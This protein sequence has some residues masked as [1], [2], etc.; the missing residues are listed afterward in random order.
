MDSQPRREHFKLRG[1]HCAACATTIERAVASVPGVIEARV[2]F[3][4]E[5]LTVSLKNGA[6]PEAITGAVEAAGYTAIEAETAAATSELDRVEARRNLGWVIF[7]AIA[8]AAVMYLQDLSGGAAGLASLGLSSLVMFS[9]GLVFYR[10][11][12]IAAR[13]RTAGMDTL[14]ALGISAA[15]LYSVFTTFPS[16]FFE[17][18]RFFDTAV[19]LI[20]FVRLGKYLEARARGRATAALRALLQLTPERATVIRDGQETTIAASAVRVGDM[21]RV[22]PGEGVPVDGVIVEGSSAVDESMLTGE[23]MPVE[24]S[25]GREVSGGTLNTA[26]PLIIRA[27]R[28]GAETTVAQIVRMVEEAQADKAPIQRLADYVAARFVPAV[29]AI[30]AVTMAVWLWLGPSGV[31]ALTAAVAVLV[32]ACPCALGLATPTAIMVGSAIG[33]RSGILFKRASA[34]ELITRVQVILF[35]KTGTLTRGK[36]ELGRLIP[37][38]CDSRR[39]LELAAAAAFGSIHPLSRAVVAYAHRDGVEPAGGEHH[40]EFPGQGVT[41][42]SDGVAIA[43]GNERLL[44]RRQIAIPDEAGS[45]AAAMGAEGV[46]PLYLAA[47]AGVIAVLGFVDPLKP[48]A[49]DTLAALRARGIRTVMLSGDNRAVVKAVA[50]RLPLDEFHAEM[51]PEDKIALVR[52][53]QES[54]A[55]VG[56]VGDGINDAPALA[57]A[58]IGIAIGSGTDVAKETGEVV[59]TRDDLYDVVQAF[60]LGRMTLRKVKQNLFWAFFY[61]V[62][63]IPIAAGVLYPSFGILLNPALAGLAMALSSVSVVGNALTL[64]FYR[65]RLLAERQLHSTAINAVAAFHA[66]GPIARVARDTGK[67]RNANM[68]PA[69][70]AFKSEA[71]LIPTIVRSKPERSQEKSAMADTL[72]CAKCGYETAM[73]PHCNRPMHVEQVNDRPK[74]VC[75]MGPGCGVDEI[76]L[77]CGDPMRHSMS[78]KTSA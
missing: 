55:F 53:F 65:R 24:K 13:N 38:G 36:P 22:R 39:A 14:I 21:V 4:T 74:L 43:L 19:E 73:P 44:A 59:L 33:L 62:M 41:C 31:M 29:I 10:G 60:E 25:V 78:A 40:Q 56:M 17:G 61:N 49:A 63:G 77:H 26:A 58:D 70:P 32:I 16:V 1:M 76:P 18:P 45:H 28:V 20:A 42:E 66:D 11:A 72:E 7:S 8:A 27:T 35:D 51:M 57:A 54:G 37:I 9:A 6:L 3:A 71:P 75:W 68:E 34:L 2:N 12:Y 69:T 50:E 52:R 23:S 47:D 48:E 30:A 5:T 64:G 67:T 15:Y 46:T